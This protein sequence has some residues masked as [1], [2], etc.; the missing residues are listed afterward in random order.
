MSAPP[1][2][3][4]GRRMSCIWRNG[5]A[6]SRSSRGT[7]AALEPRTPSVPSPTRPAFRKPNPYYNLYTA[8]LTVSY[9]PDVFGATRR[10]GR[11]RQSAVE[12]SRFQL[13]ATYLTLS[14]N[15]VVTAVQEA[16]LR[17]QIAATRAPARA[18]ASIDRDRPERQRLLG[19]ASDLDVLAQQSA[20]AQTAQTLPP[21]Q[22]QLGQSRDALTALL[23]RLPSDEPQETFRLDDLTLPTELPVSAALEAGRAAAGCPPGRGEFACRLGRGRRRDCQHAA[24]IRDHR[25]HWIECAEAAGSCSPPTR[26]SGMSGRR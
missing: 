7:S 25:R 11:D 19:T 18:A 6:S 12:S 17:G 10:A 9:L 16:S 4:C 26:D 8:Q 14:S 2:R 3:R 1:R 22:K 15:V 13:E 24:A 23:G 20:E 5:P 21:L